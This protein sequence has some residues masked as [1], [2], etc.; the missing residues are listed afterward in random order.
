MAKR[1]LQKLPDHFFVV[2]G[3]LLNLVFQAL[4]P[5]EFEK[6][7]QA[8]GFGSFEE[9]V[10]SLTDSILFQ[11]WTD[12]DVKGHL[13]MLNG[14]VGDEAIEAFLSWMGGDGGDFDIQPTAAEFFS[15]VDA[16]F[17][18]FLNS[19]WEGESGTEIATSLSEISGKE[20]PV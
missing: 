19:D 7:A 17:E 6:V 12:K 5:A 15:M 14:E 20:A 1:N 2:T 18:T 16:A 10:A 4:R 11:G 3:K 13:K 9:L 8:T